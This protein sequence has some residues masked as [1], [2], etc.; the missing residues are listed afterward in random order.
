MTNDNAT[1]CVLFIGNL[2]LQVK[3]EE[4]RRSLYLLF[5]AYGSVL[6]VKHGY[7]NGTRNYAHI[8]FEDEK[9]ALAAK[10]DLQD[11]DFLGRSLRIDLA[12]KKNEASTK[13]S[14]T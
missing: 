12:R 11:F 6:E 2:P 7:K 9:S 13:L 1:R 14:E 5:S 3:K 4:I 10:Y 8:K